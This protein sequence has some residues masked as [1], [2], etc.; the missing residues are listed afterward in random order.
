MNASKLPRFAGPPEIVDR[1]WDANMA[2][3][4]GIEAYRS[5]TRFYIA[6]LRMGDIWVPYYC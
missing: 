6:M 4:A 1:W 5:N 2:R 3:V